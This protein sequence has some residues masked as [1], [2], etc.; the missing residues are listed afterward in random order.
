MIHYC[1][2]KNKPL[3]NPKPMCVGHTFSL[4]VACLHV[5]LHSFLDQHTPGEELVLLT[6][7]T[8]GQLDLLHLH[9]QERTRKS[10]D[11]PNY[12]Q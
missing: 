7:N 1:R 9:E 3:I 5:V 8:L 4:S 11:N 10:M 2:H 6:G 12:H